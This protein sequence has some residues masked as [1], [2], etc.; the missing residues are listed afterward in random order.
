ML[1]SISMLFTPVFADYHLLIFALPA[2]FA[3]KEEQHSTNLRSHPF[4][5]GGMTF[6]ASCIML[7]PLNYISYS[8]LYITSLLKI[9]VALVMMYFLMSRNPSEL[10]NFLRRR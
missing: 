4:S 1:A 9:P 3:L 8:G 5:I 7:S 10:L 2:L 6:I